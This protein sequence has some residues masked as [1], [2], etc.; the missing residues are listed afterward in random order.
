MSGKKTLR[1][2]S[3]RFFQCRRRPDDNSQARLSSRFRTLSSLISPLLFSLSFLLSDRTNNER[4]NEWVTPRCAHRTLVNRVP[5]PLILFPFSFLY[6]PNSPSLSHLCTSIASSGEVS[7]PDV[8]AYDA[9][10]HLH[11]TGGPERY[12]RVETR[13][14]L[15]LRLV[16]NHPRAIG[17]LF[18]PL[19]VE[20]RPIGEFGSVILS[21]RFEFPSVVSVDRGYTSRIFL[22]S[23][24]TSPSP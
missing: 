1:F 8:G 20:P 14:I 18:P 24:T 19:E 11:K 12:R 2:I 7:C 13:A 22:S 9:L 6:F 17:N 21:L 16:E 15:S 10:V 4:T 23:E 5:V 3:V